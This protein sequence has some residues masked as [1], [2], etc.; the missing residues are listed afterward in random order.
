[1]IKKGTKKLFL[2]LALFSGCVINSNVQAQVAVKTNLLYDATTTP[3]IGME[4]G[5][6]RR[7]TAQLFYGINPWEFNSTTHGTRMAKH[8]L[9]MPEYRW[10]P[11][12]KFNGHF[13]GVHAMGGQFNA[14]NVALPMPG[15]FFGGDN[16][17]KEVRN[18]SYEG[19]FLGAGFT[20]GYQWIL[21]RHFNL[22]AEAGIGYNRVWYDKYMCGECGAKIG[23]GNTNYVG[24]TKLGISLIYLF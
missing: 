11:C 10:W 18:H 15:K 1:M 8:W 24:L 7:S 14:S 9:L 16:L 20:Y 5:L 12:S 22:E 3:N 2:A 21:N 17:T 19:A 13:I 6:G 23:D 4:F